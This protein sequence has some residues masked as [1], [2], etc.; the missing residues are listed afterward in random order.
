[1][2]ANF[3]DAGSTPGRTAESEIGQYSEGNYGASGSV[4][5]VRKPHTDTD[6][7]TGTGTDTQE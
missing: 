4:N 5:P 1:V 6:T 2:K 3:G 7:D